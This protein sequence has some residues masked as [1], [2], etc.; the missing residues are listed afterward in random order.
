[1]SCCWGCNK[2]K[3]FSL[4]TGHTCLQIKWQILDDIDDVVLVISERCGFNWQILKCP[5]SNCLQGRV[6][7]QQHLTLNLKLNPERMR[8]FSQK[9]YLV[10]LTK[11]QPSDKKLRG[12]EL[13]WCRLKILLEQNKNHLYINKRA[14]RGWKIFPLE[15]VRWPGSRRNPGLTASIMKCLSRF[16][17]EWG[18]W[19]IWAETTFIL[20]R[21]CFDCCSRLRE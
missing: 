2:T 19:Q 8:L 1:M 12:F 4:S 5:D 9:N 16:H 15:A 13:T 17:E 10:F 21:I 18:I 20:K 14:S 3:Y 6:N 11:I 7:D